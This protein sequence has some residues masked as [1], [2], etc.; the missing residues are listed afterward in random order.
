MLFNVNAKAGGQDGDSGD[1]RKQRTQSDLLC[2]PLSTIRRTV[3]TV[4]G[5]GNWQFLASSR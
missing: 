3:G 5:S 4:L 2:N 1:T